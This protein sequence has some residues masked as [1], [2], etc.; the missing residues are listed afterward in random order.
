MELKEYFESVKGRGVLATADGEGRVDAAVYATPHFIEDEKIVYGHTG[1]IRDHRAS[2][3][4]GE[5]HVDTVEGEPYFFVVQ[6]EYPY[7]HGR[8]NR[9]S[10]ASGPACRPASASRRGGWAWFPR[11]SLS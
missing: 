10:M 3:G 4:V 11:S 2:Q 8:S 6:I 5:G 1:D 7:L 9:G